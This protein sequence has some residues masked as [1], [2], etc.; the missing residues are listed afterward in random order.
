MYG[1][2]YRHP[3]EGSAATAPGT[4]GGL[5]VLVMLLVGSAYAQ[6]N[7]ERL[8]GWRPQICF[9]VP[10]PQR[11]GCVVLNVTPIPDRDVCVALL[12]ALIEYY[13]YDRVT[14]Q[15]TNNLGAVRQ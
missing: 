14:C 6:T 1:L 5:I 13:K 9:S 15:H 8:E 12:P 11:A 4:F 2:R 7:P 10:T 3:A